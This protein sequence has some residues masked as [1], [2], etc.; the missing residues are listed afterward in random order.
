MRGRKSG[1]KRKCRKKP[2]RKTKK[3]ECEDNRKKTTECIWDLDRSFVKKQNDYFVAFF[4]DNWDS[5]KIWLK[6]KIKPLIKLSLPKS[7]IH[8]VERDLYASSSS[9]FPSLDFWCNPPHPYPRLCFALCVNSLHI[10]LHSYKQT[11]ERLSIPTSN[12]KQKQIDLSYK[13]WFQIVLAI[14]IEG[15]WIV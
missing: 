2:K 4:W 3:R 9:F 12:R 10:R 14:S 13:D 11:T 6:P 8:I 7:L 5:I 15:T 1:L